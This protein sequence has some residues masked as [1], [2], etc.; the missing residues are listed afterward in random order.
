V[1]KVVM[2]TTDQKLDR[3]IV[4]EARTLCRLGYRVVIL[5]APWPEGKE[6]YGN[7]P[8]DLIR[9]G[10]VADCYSEYRIGKYISAGY[11]LYYWLKKREPLLQPFIPL[12]R[13]FFRAYLLDLRSFYLRFFLKEAIAEGGSIYH[14]HDLQPLVSGSMAAERLGAKLVYDSHELF[15]EQ[16][17]P[18]GER[19]KWLK[20]ENSYIH[21][22]D[23]VITVNG[24]I[25]RELEKRYGIIRPV[26]IL[27][28]ESRHNFEESPAA[29]SHAL[30]QQLGLPQ[31]TLLILYQGGLIPNR[32]LENLVQSFA[33]VRTSRAVLV[34]LGSGE[35]EGKLHELV[36]NRNLAKRVFLIPGVP[37]EALLQITS[38]AVLGII[39]YSATCLNTFYCTPN[40]LFEYIAAGVPLLVSNL[41][42]VRNIVETYDLGWVNDFNTPERIAASIDCALSREEHLRKC[43]ENAVRAFE[44]LCWEEEEK[45]LIA[46]Y[47]DL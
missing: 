18:S 21:R 29:V 41:P 1:K 28:C 4:L 16:E 13:S 34:V 26:V 39:P 35:L 9:A 27:N 23:R 3:R 43:R 2:L 8:F 37:Q 11:R 36:Q 31:E 14:V 25:A 7:E 47:E 24:S 44:T 38:Q 45:K 46:L 10:N 42:E 5:A 30:F 40:K 15:V 17:F 19:S 33:Y 20:I 6:T 32:N 12:M 22:A